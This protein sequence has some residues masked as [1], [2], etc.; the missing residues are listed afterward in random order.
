MF[1]R[2]VADR[3][4]ARDAGM[5]TAEYAMGMIAAVG[6][7]VVLYKVLNSPAVRGMLQGMVGQAFDVQ[8]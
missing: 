8:F 4:A 6:L 5:V 1:R 2:V 3:P 7:A